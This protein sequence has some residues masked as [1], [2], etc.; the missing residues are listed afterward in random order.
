MANFFY[1]LNIFR[2]DFISSDYVC[3]PDCR[4]SLYSLVEQMIPLVKEG[5]NNIFTFLLNER[6]FFN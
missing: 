6:K 4:R 5:I 1:R 3:G 2:S